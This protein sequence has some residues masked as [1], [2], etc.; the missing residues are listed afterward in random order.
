MENTTIV[1]IATP[2]GNAGVGIIRLSGSDSL[3]IV[4]RCFTPQNPI[5]KPHKKIK[6][7]EKTPLVFKPRTATLATLETP[8]FTDQVI[9]IHF[10]APNSFTGEDIVEIQAHGGA[11]LLQQIVEHLTTLG[12]TP[13]APGEFSRR[14]FMNGKLSLDQAEAIIETIHAESQTH[15]NATSKVLSGELREKLFNI[16]AEIIHTLAQLEATLDNPEADIMHVT[17][18]TI[19]LSIKFINDELNTLLQTADTGRIIANGINVAVLGKPNVGKSSLFNALLNHD[20]SIVTDIAGTTRD[21]IT[22]SIHYRGLRIIFHD[23]AGVHKVVGGNGNRP[24]I[25]GIERTKEIVKNADIALAIFDASKKP[26]P[27]DDEIVK[28]TKNKLTLIALNKNDLDTCKNHLPLWTKLVWNKKYIHTSAL[29][30]ENVDKLK[31]LIYDTVTKD[32]LTTKSTDIILTN[33]RHIRE[34][35]E[36]TRQLDSLTEKTLDCIAQDLTTA[37]HHIGNVTGTNASEAVIDEI[38]S[39]FCLGK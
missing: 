30:G 25:L 33:Q 9:V 15:L 4:S 14:A 7:S 27:E 36:A 17:T 29:S 28:L 13:A 2:I 1:A 12:A 18:E 8:T 23:T 16:E 11:F 35:Q 10:P 5:G 31:E 21:T 37:L 3:S 39:R 20:R 19:Q 22:E 38:F 32:K 24:E 26:T 6:N 34:L